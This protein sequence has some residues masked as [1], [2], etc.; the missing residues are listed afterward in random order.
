MKSLRLFGVLVVLSL[1]T[2][3]ATART[4]SSY[5]MENS[6]LAS[7]DVRAIGVDA[8]NVTW[9]GTTD[10]LS[11]YDG[12]AWTTYTV[13]DKLASNAINAITGEITELGPV[14]WLGTNGGVSVIA[15]KETNAI[16]AAT[17]YTQE[18]TGLA[19][20]MIQSVAV[21]STATKWF[22]TEAGVST[23]D[24]ENWAT[25]TNLDLLSNN[26][27]LAIEVAPD[28]WIYLGTFGGGVSRVDGLS[29]A[30]PY[31]TSWSGIIS[32]NV[33]AI[34]FDSRGDKWF[35]TDAGLSKHTGDDTKSGW[36][37]WTTEDG[38]VHNLVYSIAEDSE[39]LLW[40]GTLNGV[41]SFDGSTWTSYTT[42][43]GIAGNT[44][45]DIEADRSGTL[46]FATNA[47]V[48]RY[49]D[50]PSAVDESGAIPSLIT[51]DGI[52]PNPFN[53]ETTIGFSLP[54]EGLVT[55]DIYS[56]SGQKIRT[57]VSD[58][59]QAGRYSVVW[60]GRDMNGAPV[61][62]GVYIVRLGMDS[63]IASQRITLVR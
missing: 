43:N 59:R 31:D 49:G 27:V 52:F 61:A 40:I 8:Y 46:W 6:G 26:N 32:D 34:L 45:Y 11:R 25:H 23:F 2:V 57:L 44:V 16:T 13:S 30:S 24:G 37:T 4:W 60:G 29:T 56:M 5:T 53:P 9:F 54:S 50:E 18:N 47:G 10:G 62:S 35:G 12:K 39:G 58:T 51:I 22:G 7:G 21:D 19:A 38:L 14:L 36:T 42:D 55:L 17:P 63:I 48:S 1:C 20:L 3:P 41:S 33:Y 15:V 28:G